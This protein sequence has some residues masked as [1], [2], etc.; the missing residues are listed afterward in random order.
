MGRACSS[1]FAATRCPPYMWSVIALIGAIMAMALAA[2]MLRRPGPGQSHSRWPGRR[3]RPSITLSRTGLGQNL[4]KHSIGHPAWVSWSHNVQVAVGQVDLPLEMTIRACLPGGP[5]CAASGSRLAEPGWWERGTKSS[6]F[7]SPFW[8]HGRQNANFTRSLS[9]TEP[10]ESVSPL[11]S[12]SKFLPK[13]LLKF[14]K[15]SF[16]IP[17]S[18]AICLASYMGAMRQ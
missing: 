15:F 17:V 10:C 3:P 4:V 8:F 13:F 12:F 14:V 9:I 16:T 7:N 18:P 2:S 1:S 11:L 5:S 6:R